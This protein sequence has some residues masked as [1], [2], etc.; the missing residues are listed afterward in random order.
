MYLFTMSSSEDS[1]KSKHRVFSDGEDGY[2]LINYKNKQF[3]AI[4]EGVRSFRRNR[5]FTNPVVCFLS[6]ILFNKLFGLQTMW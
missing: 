5:L 1:H 6:T 4:S 3:A 2:A